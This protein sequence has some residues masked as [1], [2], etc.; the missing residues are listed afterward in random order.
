[1]ESI[2]LTVALK[3]DALEGRLVAGEIPAFIYTIPFFHNPTGA[4][5]PTERCERL[6]SLAQEYGFSII[7]DEPYNFLRFDGPSLPSLASYDDTGRVVSLGSFSKIL[8][9]GLR[10]GKCCLL[11]CRLS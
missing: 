10:L 11:L 4:V 7:A 3:V 6:V 8:S 1:M 5:M 9:P 2:L